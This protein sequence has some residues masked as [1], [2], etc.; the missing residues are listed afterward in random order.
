MQIANKLRA[1]LFLASNDQGSKLGNVARDLLEA[2]VKFKM[3][4]FTVWLLRM[5]TADSVNMLKNVKEV[6]IES[7]V[8]KR[9]PWNAKKQTKD[10]ASGGD[11]ND[12]SVQFDKLERNF[13]GT[14][15]P[16]IVEIGFYTTAHLLGIHVAY[17]DGTIFEAKGNSPDASTY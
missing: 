16:H 17:S 4:T 10:F 3:N 2:G 9:H 13:K 14:T 8:K 12:A 7:E 6:G 5:M 1:Q 15:L 11:G